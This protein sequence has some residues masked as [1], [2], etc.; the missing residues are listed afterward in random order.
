MSSSIAHE[1]QESGSPETD[2]D[3]GGNTDERRS[4]WRR[5]A[6]VVIAPP[7]FGGLVMA[8]IFGWQ[9]FAPT[10]MPR[11]ALVQGAI[12][13][14]S[15]TMGYAV[16]TVLGRL[17]R[18]L[19][20]STNRSISHGSW[21]KARIVLATVAGI[22]T[23]VGVVM[24]L[25][26]QNRQRDLLGMDHLGPANIIVVI[27]A[28]VVLTAILFVI[29]RL[30][31][32]A[33]RSLDRW[34]NKR[35]P[36]IISVTITVIVVSVVANYALRDVAFSHFTVWA[37]TTFGEKDASI[38]KTLTPPESP[39]VSGS[40]D[41]LVTW[42]SLG[43]QGRA[44]VADVTTRE[45]LADYWGEDAT[46]TD[47][48]RAY[49]GVG[50]GDMVDNAKTAVAELDRAGGF[51]RGV[52]VVATATGSGWIDPDAARAIEM[53]HKGDTAIVTLQYSFLP[54]WIS[55]LVGLDQSAEAGTDLFNA[56]SDHWSQ[57]PPDQR[58]KLIVFG[59]SLGSYGAESAFA[60]VNA[61][62]SLANVMARTDGVLL[63]GPTNFNPMHEQ[64]VAGRDKG[65]SVWLPVFGEQE[66]VVFITRDPSQN[67]PDEP[68]TW[69]LVYV[70]HTSDPVTHWGFNWLWSP[71]GWN[72]TPRGFDVPNTG[73]WFPFVTWTQ[74]V[75]DLMAGFSA[76]P[77]FGHDYR[78]D[79]VNAWSR[80][81]PP[82][83]WSTTERDRLMKYLNED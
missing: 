41:S 37:D 67:V 65:S 21:R 13:A 66:D 43:M 79:Y 83:D 61:E 68:A 8:L 49:V 32:A 35:I 4:R 44:F 9:S 46:F 56:V 17:V 78:L 54:S 36:R 62:T 26:W 80:V 29:G 48:V 47:P 22:A 76:P 71:S 31:G 58:P 59:L 64:L 7:T 82:D 1:D 15:I 45:Q 14:I 3:Q 28:G 18:Y 39:T 16:G 73:T 19:L 55:F 81:V 75:F 63:A 40:P 23:V 70:Q 27:I 25:A 74:G 42:E 77:G 34:L 50:D 69:P 51:D 6:D 2:S 12:C 72:E 60:G 57:L 52:L 20:K 53:M 38:D 11:T 33:V 30:I 5:I 10:L 24:W